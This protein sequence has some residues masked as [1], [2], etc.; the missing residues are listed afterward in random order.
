MS[1]HN[2]TSAD[3]PMAARTVCGGARQA[4]HA[5]ERW[6]ETAPLAIS[7]QLLVHAA[8]LKEI[9]VLSRHL[10]MRVAFRVH[11]PAGEEDPYPVFIPASGAAQ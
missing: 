11:Q 2:D 4:T 5:Y 7:E 3:L 6:R 10:G 8:L 1:L 9:N